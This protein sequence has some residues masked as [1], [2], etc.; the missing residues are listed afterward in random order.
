VRRGCPAL[1]PIHLPLR[2]LA[3]SEIRP[4]SSKRLRAPGSD[5]LPLV[6]SGRERRT[7]TAPASGAVSR[8][9]AENKPETSAHFPGHARAAEGGTRGASRNTRGGRAPPIPAASSTVG[10]GLLGRGPR[11]AAAQAHC[12]AVGAPTQQRPLRHASSPAV[13]GVSPKT[14]GQSKHPARRGLQAT[15]PVAFPI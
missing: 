1:S 13:F 10:R 7:G 12:L 9:L 8:G 6:R 4:G 14:P 2:H 15:G 11:C 3:P 5:A